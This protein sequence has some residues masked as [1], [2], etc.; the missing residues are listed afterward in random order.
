MPLL[1][2]AFSVGAAIAAGV[3]KGA[4]RHPRFTAPFYGV[5]AIRAARSTPNTARERVLR[6]VRLL[7]PRLR[8]GESI[9]HSTA[10][11]LYGCPIRVGTTLH[12]T[13]QPGI[14]ASRANGVVGHQAGHAIS[15]RFAEGIPVVPAPIALQQAAASVPLR[16]LVVAIDHFR[17]LRGRGEGRPLLNDDDLLASIHGF[18]GRGARNLRVALSL[19]LTGAESRMETLTRLLLVAH[20][21]ASSFALQVD[22]KDA[23]GWIG[24]FDLVDAEKRTIVEFDGDQHRTD[25]SQYERDITRL[26]RARAAGYTVIQLRSGDVLDRPTQTAMRVAEA[27]GAGLRPHPLAES[28]LAKRL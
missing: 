18:H 28:L 2:A 12:I 16:E 7:L 13:S 24:R 5:R 17:C 22:V 14:A 3:S 1:P 19:S 11:H 8:D 23:A 20:G 10:L 21:L 4:L 27:L 25:K 6:D 9:S 26:D 15:V